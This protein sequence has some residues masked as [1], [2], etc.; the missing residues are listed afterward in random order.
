M[1]RYVDLILSEEPEEAA[2]IAEEIASRGDYP[3]E[4]TVQALWYVANDHV[5]G[6]RWADAIEVIDRVLY[7]SEQRVFRILRLACAYG[8][9]SGDPAREL[10]FLTTST[11][12]AEPLGDASARL[13]VGQREEAR[14][15]LSRCSMDTLRNVGGSP[16]LQNLAREAMAER[17]G[18]R[19]E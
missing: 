6:K 15:A 17:G 13:L 5:R 7:V 12:D 18:Q 3:P 2:R 1:L 11:P 8:S 19:D 16:E 14:R 10:R 4:M 9:G